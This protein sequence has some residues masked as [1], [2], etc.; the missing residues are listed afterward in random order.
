MAAEQLEHALQ[1]PITQTYAE[2]LGLRALT[3]V[4]SWPDALSRFLVLSGADSKSLR[5][6]AAAPECLAAVLEFLLTSEDLLTQFCADEAVDPRTV[7]L[8][9]ARL[10]M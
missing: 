7:H 3:F 9:A 8:A 5:Q 10:G 1:I 4:A 2:T 6:Y